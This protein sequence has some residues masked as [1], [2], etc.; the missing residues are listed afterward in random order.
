VE[1][2][3]DIESWPKAL[4]A[5]VAASR[6]FDRARVVRE[7][8][9]TQDAARAAAGGRPGLVLVAGRQTRGRGRHGRVWEQRGDLGVAM[10]AVVEAAESE[11]LSKVAGLAAWSAC[12]CALDGTE[13]GGR[14]RIKAPNDVVVDE[15]GG[16]RRKLAG[17][18]IEQGDGLAM[19]GIGVN[20]LQGRADFGLTVRGTACSLAM[21]GSAASRLD[22]MR[23]LVHELARRLAG[24]PAEAAA[25]WERARA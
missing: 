6:W 1:H 7:T 9:S 21:L 19:I 17:V 18:L 16:A 23:S 24:G 22:V 8:E 25:A 3:D 4:E 2:P 11:F 20:V 5:A 10:T 15:P 14:V 12:R 13:A